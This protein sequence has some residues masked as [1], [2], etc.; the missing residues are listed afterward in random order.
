MKVYTDAIQKIKARRHR[1]PAAQQS[2]IDVAIM[3]LER[4]NGNITPAK[5]V[6]YGDPAEW[7]CCQIY[8]NAESND[9]TFQ[10]AIRF[11]GVK[12]LHGKAWS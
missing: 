3:L 10:A 11:L 4:A 7:A 5:M 1:A 8:N 6:E 2:M 12:V 9:Q